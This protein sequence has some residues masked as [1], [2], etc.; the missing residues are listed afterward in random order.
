MVKKDLE[1]LYHTEELE[2]KFLQLKRLSKNTSG[3]RPT[4]IP[5]Q[6]S[7]GVRRPVLI[8]HIRKLKQYKARLES[9]LSDDGKR[10]EKMDI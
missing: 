5:A 10:N 7:Y 8:D 9:E 6:D 3:W 4:A 2:S 1:E